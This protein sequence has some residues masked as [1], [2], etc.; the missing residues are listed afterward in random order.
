[1]ALQSISSPAIIPSY[2]PQSG[3]HTLSGE[4][5]FNRSQGSTDSHMSTALNSTRYS[6]ESMELTYSNKDGDTVSLSMEHVELQKTL[7]SFG[8]ASTPEQWNE[9]VGKVKDEF[10]KF[11]QTI[12]E[13]MIN[14]LRSEEQNP[15]VS[16]SSEPSEEIEGLPEYWNAENT[17]QRI[18]DFA[19]SFYGIA[20]ADGKAYYDM[21]KS[22][23]QEGFDQAM[24]MLGERPEAV[25]NLSNRTFEL[26]LKKLDEWAAS[27]GI[28]IGEEALQV[29]A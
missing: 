18:V 26:A 5:S 17:S 15:E 1:M 29:A 22:A 6:S 14:S 13:K 2:T 23:M 24:G 25:S 16:E 4:K 9:I 12:I 11:Q 19:T 20:E 3:A 8:N 21:M 7:L 27:Q 28:D 10:L